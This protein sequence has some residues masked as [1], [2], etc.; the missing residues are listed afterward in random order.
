MNERQKNDLIAAG[1]GVLY[2]NVGRN[3]MIMNMLDV[4]KGRSDVC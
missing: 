3:V 1:G 4:L 2:R